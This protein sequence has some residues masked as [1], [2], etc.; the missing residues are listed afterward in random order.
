[1]IG[2]R[3]T[4]LRF[5]TSSALSRSGAPSEL[6]ERSRQLSALGDA[7]AAVV[8]SSDGRLLFVA[9]EAGGG[10]TALLRRFCDERRSAARILWGAC[11]AL[12][13][14]RPLGPLL[15]VAERAGGEL[16]QVV[17]NAARPYDVAA[18]LVRELRTASPTILVLEDLHWADEATLDV[19]RLLARR[20]EAVPALVLASYRDDEL[21][22]AHPLRIMLGELATSEAI[23]RV[24]IDPLSPAAVAELAG[25]AG[26]DAE[27]L[28]RQTLGN[29][30]FVTEVVAAGNLEIP[31]TVRDAVL[32]RTAR[33]RPAARA[34]I[35]AVAVVP[36]RTELWLLDALAG[37]AVEQLD[38]CLASGILTPEPGDVAFRHELAR[39]A[40]EESLSPNRRLALHRAALAALAAPPT[41]APDVARLAH[42]AEAADDA[43]AVLEF[44]PAAA[45]QAAARGAH[46]QGADQYARA[47]RFGEALPLARRAELLQRLSDELHLTDADEEALEAGRQA[48]ACFRKLGDTRKVG[49]YLPRL[50]ELLRPV[51][52]HEEADRAVR[53]A[54]ALLESL[55]PGRELA[56]AYA[57]IAFGRM[58]TDDEAGATKWATK[59]IELGERLDD[60][61]SVVR[62][63]TSIGASEISRGAADEGLG[64][65]ERALA[66]ALDGGHEVAAARA[67]NFL[68][69]AAIWLR[70]LPLGERYLRAGLEYTGERGLDRIRSRLLAWRARLELERCRWDEAGETAA[71]LLR[72]PRLD[73][74]P[75]VIAL[76]VLGLVRAR[77]GDPGRWSLLEE[78][79]QLAACS[80]E[81][82]PV[83]IV[84]AARAEA[85]WLEGEPQQIDAATK[86]VFARALGVGDPWAIGELAV[87]RWRAR[88]LDDPPAGAAQPYSLQIAG[89][90]ARAAERWTEIGCPYDAAL[91][92]AWADDED[93]LRRAHDQLQRLGAQPAARILARRLRERGARGIR[94]GPRATTQESPA[95]LTRRELEVLAL[96][97]GGLH[98][99]E[100]AERLFLS[101]RTVDHHVSAI[102]RKLGV[103]TRRQATAEAARLGLVGQDR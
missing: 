81:L 102:L 40:V 16:E 89:D 33:L 86:D 61:D 19:L 55:P 69:S 73:W 44:A 4:P 85:A 64:R 59:A 77:R 38:A 60:V 39:L 79:A 15:D 24:K 99:A 75:R 34:L 57:D 54:V 48:L 78:A 70:R 12:F 27:A 11:D 72:L 93:A 46:R 90:W 30:F 67:Y 53:E 37:E 82:Q 103:H 6:F 97:A 35:D 94:R 7:F 5:V 8:K 68:S 88:L 66:L 65:L 36:L 21:D 28:Y 51:G 45:E 98:N 3:E 62:A 47:L 74:R 17:E 50:S 49:H 91:A 43:K 71:L 9:G 41:G 84:G 2:G 63:L 1:M 96:V 42:H 100:I 29:P 18:S 26:L 20:L 58:L 23:G 56:A 95:G 101:K 32:A 13:T 87:W 52:L 14:P 25:P 76:V 10:K 80:P 22:R 83:T 92:L 31:D